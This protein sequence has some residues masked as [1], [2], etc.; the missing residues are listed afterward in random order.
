[1]PPKTLAEQSAGPC[2]PGEGLPRR[3][4]EAGPVGKAP[5]LGG[6]PGSSRVVSLVAGLHAV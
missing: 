6:P 4:G 1:M 2:P 5:W 3:R